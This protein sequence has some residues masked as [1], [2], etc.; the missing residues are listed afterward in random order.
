MT[1]KKVSGFRFQVSGFTRPPICCS[2]GRGTKY[3]VRGANHF[4][5]S[6]FRFQVSGSR[7]VAGGWWLTARRAV[8]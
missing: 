6:G 3:G 1:G 4:Q 8:V 7:L 5:V 2:G